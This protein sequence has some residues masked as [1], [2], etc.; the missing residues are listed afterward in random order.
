MEILNEEGVSRTLDGASSISP[1]EELK[2]QA[3]AILFAAEHAMEVSE[4]RNVIGEVSLSDVRLAL[5]DLM[6]DYA[7]RS[8]FL[9]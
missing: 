4:I 5:K 6:A 8:F 1:F 2:K 3:E 7:P 9:F